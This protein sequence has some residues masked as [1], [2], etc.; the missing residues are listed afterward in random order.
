MYL[1]LHLRVGLILWQV[2]VLFH[3]S[4]YPIV[5]GTNISF[6][7]KSKSLEKETFIE[8]AKQKACLL[9]KLQVFLSFFQ[10]EKWTKLTSFSFVI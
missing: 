10:T 8:L 2:H 6:G 1:A 7:G 3:C 4:R 5:L 9:I